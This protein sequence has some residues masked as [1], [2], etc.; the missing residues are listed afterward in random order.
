[1]DKFNCKKYKSKKAGDSI[2]KEPCYSGCFL[3]VRGV[4]PLEKG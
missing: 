3:W 4:L 2:F 1:V